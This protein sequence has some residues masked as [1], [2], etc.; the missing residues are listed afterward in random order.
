MTEVVS[1]K[2]KMKHRKM[3]NLKTDK[4]ILIR[5]TVKDKASFSLVRQKLVK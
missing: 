5:K 3:N 1:L 2:L 4:K